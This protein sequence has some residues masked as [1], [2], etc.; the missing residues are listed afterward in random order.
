MA[1]RP[2]VDGNARG[3]SP[4]ALGEVEALVGKAAH[5]LKQP[6]RHIEIFA[7]RLLDAVEEGAPDLEAIHAIK[8]RTALL[9]RYV[10]ELR[11]YVHAVADPAHRAPL[12]I[13]AVFD[14]L[15]RLP[16]G[17][18]G[19]S[20]DALS[21]RGGGN[22]AADRAL[23]TGALRAVVENAWRHNPDRSVSV[24]VSATVDE[25]RVLFRVADDGRGVDTRIAAT[26]F[27][28]F[29]RLKPKGVALR[30]LGLGL[31]FCRAVAQAHG[32]DA[33]FAAPDAALDAPSPGC[34]VEIDFPAAP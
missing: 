7:D 28:P 26:A 17:L 10:D 9:R 29:T 27:E 25:G 6:I 19:V 16:A 13:D 15:K 33:R 31:A 23:L 5:D 2:P 11:A 14:A 30:G 4:P 8:D 1:E 32:G 3:A 12:S 34:I 18:D 21:C 22:I 24:S 20:A